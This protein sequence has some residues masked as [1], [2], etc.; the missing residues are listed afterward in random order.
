MNGDL[1]YPG[2][3]SGDAL[4]VTLEQLRVV[5]RFGLQRDSG[6]GSHAR[7]HH[8]RRQESRTKPVE[9][10]MV[11]YMWSSWKILPFR[12]SEMVDLWNTEKS[13]MPFTIAFLFFFFS[14][15]LFLSLRNSHGVLR[16]LSSEVSVRF[17]WS[18]Y[19]PDPI[20]NTWQP[21]KSGSVS[22]PSSTP[23]LSCCVIGTLCVCLLRVLV[24]S[25]FGNLSL[26]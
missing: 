10:I 9:R 23:P 25:R 16:S 17:S 12:N 19:I 21:T 1:P 5:H 24:S 11:A 2:L 8:C 3:L 14:L 18:A 13:S 4:D 7:H 22:C 6:G 20:P 15:V 26:C